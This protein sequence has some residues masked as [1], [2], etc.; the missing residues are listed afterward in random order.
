MSTPV[1]QSVQ[2]VAHVEVLRGVRAAKDVRPRLLVE[3][4][5]GADRAVHYGLLEKR[6]Q[7]PL[8]AGLADFF[9]VN[10][11]VAAWDLGRAVA[12]R[13][14]EVRP[15][16]AALIVRC[17]VPRTFVDCNRELDASAQGDLKKGGVTAGIPPYVTNPADHALLRQLHARYISLTD[18][19]YE[20]V[21]A[22]GGIA[23]VPHTYAPRTVGIDKVDE[24]I[25]R[26]LHRVYAADLVETWPLRPEVDLITRDADGVQ[27]AIPNAPERLKAVLA[28]VGVQAVDSETYWLHPATRAATLSRRYPGRLLCFEVRRDLVVKAWTPFAEME[29]DPDKV[30]RIAGPLAMVI[31]GAVVDLDHFEAETAD[32]MPPR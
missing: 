2:G 17:L 14:V 19:A 18:D 3:V 25:V 23:L 15:D 21:V 24:N 29:A 26:E 22:E 5:H 30:A 1:P 27:L 10:T 20:A 6:L 12:E 4:P 11:D 13:F 31:E 28:D 9:F 8:P 7:G 32:V 16:E